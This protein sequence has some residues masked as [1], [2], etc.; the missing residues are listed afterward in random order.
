MEFAKVGAGGTFMSDFI[1]DLIDA[2][3]VNQLK[4]ADEEESTFC[5]YVY[6]ITRSS[7]K[8]LGSR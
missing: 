1:D 2:L 6:T 7:H 5:G 4:F 3:E 8:S